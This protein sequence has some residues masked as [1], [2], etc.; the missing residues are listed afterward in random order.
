MES[1]SASSPLLHP[2]DDDEVPAAA[3]GASPG[4]EGS[5]VDRYISMRK[6]DMALF[7]AIGLFSDLDQGFTS[8]GGFARFVHAPH[9]DA[10]PQMLSMFIGGILGS[11]FATFVLTGFRPTVRV[12]VNSSIMVLGGVFCWTLQSP[13]SVYLGYGFLFMGQFSQMSTIQPLTY[14]VSAYAT[15]LY[16]AGF[17]FSMLVGAAIIKIYDRAFGVDPPKAAYMLTVIAFPLVVLGLFSCLD[18][19]SLKID[20]DKSKGS[21]LTLDT[22]NQSERKSSTES[23]STRLSKVEMLA[24]LNEIGLRYIPLYCVLATLLAIWMGSIANYFNS[25][26][27]SHAG[28]TANTIFDAMDNVTLVYASISAFIGLLLLTPL[29]KI[30]SGMSIFIMW[31]P[32][33]VY[34]ALITT[35]LVGLF[36]N[37]FPPMTGAAYWIV[38]LLCNTFIPIITQSFL[39]LFLSADKHVT[40]RFNEFQAQIGLLIFQVFI[41]IGTLFGLIWFSGEVYSQCVSNYEANYEGV[42]CDN[43]AT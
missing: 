8:T 17:N 34:L 3:A 37:A 12:L 6:R 2:I 36:Q 16:Q 13:A 25:A 39:P 18:Q 5:A 7:F 23:E 33:A 30:V 11:L 41:F 20:V 42:S 1:S 14:Y 15:T 24:A 27:L 43:F 28:N 26:S 9:Y 35:V 19:S 40:Q 4:D 21:V 31:I 32:I 38:G 29:G 22:E 10:A